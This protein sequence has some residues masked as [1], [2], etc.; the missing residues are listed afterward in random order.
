MK[1]KK[2]LF[3]ILLIGALL[4]IPF[5]NIKVYA[6]SN[7]ILT[8]TTQNLLEEK[9]KIIYKFTDVTESVVEVEE[10]E[11]KELKN[12][13]MSELTK[14]QR[15]R[16]QMKADGLTLKEIA[17]IEGVHFTTIDESIKATQKKVNKLREK[18][19]KKF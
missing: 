7:S 3:I 11:Q 18:Y 5:F 17:E 15:R 2:I 16:I 12:Y 1:F 13:V 6:N 10:Q 8:D 19:F 14:T 9:M 4:S